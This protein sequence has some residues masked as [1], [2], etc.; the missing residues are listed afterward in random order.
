MDKPLA[1]SQRSQNF[2]DLAPD[3]C[4]MTD[5]QGLVQ[6]ANGLAKTLFNLRRNDWQDKPIS[7]FIATSDHACIATLLEHLTQ[8]AS[9]PSASS[10]PTSAKGSAARQSKRDGQRPVE[11]YRTGHT[12]LVVEKQPIAIKP[13]GKTA[14]PAAL[15]LSVERDRQGQVV[16]LYWFFQDVRSNPTDPVTLPMRTDIFNNE[17]LLI[18]AMMGAQAG[19]WD[20]D[21]ALD[22]LT[23]S[24]ETYYLH[25]L[26]P[27]IGMVS[28]DH[29]FHQ[30]LHP[31]DRQAVS[32]YLAHAWSQQAS[33]IQLEF[34]ILHPQ[35]GIR[36]LLSVGC[37]TFNAQGTPIHLNGINLDITDRKQLEQER[38]RFLAISSD[39]RVIISYD[40]PSFRWVSPTFEPTLGWTAEEMTSRPWAEFIHPD[41]LDIS[42]AEFAKLLTGHET[43]AFENRFRHQDGSYHWL[44]WK[45]QSYPEER[46]IYGA[47]ID[48]TEK[49]QIEAQFYQTQ[50]L[51]SLGTLASG[52]AH[53]LNNVLT[54]MLAMAQLL[55]LT[56]P[57]LDERTQQVLTL[58]ETSA[59]RG[60]N[61]V[62]QILTFTRGTTGEPMTLQI[63]PLL[64][65]VMGIIQQTFPQSIDLRTTFP[66]TPLWSISADPTHLH[67][68]LMNLCLNARDAMPYGGELTLTADN[69]EVDEVFARMNFN[70]QVGQ[71]V[72]VTIADTGEGIAPAMRDRIFEPFFTTK[73]QAKGTGLGLSTVLGIVKTY[74]GFV[75]V[76]S[77]VGRGSQFKVYLPTT[78]EPVS[79]LEQELSPLQGQG[80]LVLIIDDDPAIQFATQALLEQYQY[81]TMIA[82]DGIEALE[83]YA[84]RR[85]EIQV[86]LMDVMMP[87]MDGIITARTFRKIN[88]QVQ[89]IAMSG[90]S[91]KREPVLAAGAK[92][93]LAKPYT[94]EELL[95]TVS[96]IVSSL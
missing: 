54:P 20:W 79:E 19:S 86:V 66:E 25:G 65:D 60:A 95:K 48:I 93:F 8:E 53:D 80:E 72:R 91:T 15:T 73:D 88:P 34:R 71:Y 32:D 50:R 52:I 49:K 94:A 74:G 70:A 23:W 68:V 46:V 76:E 6:A 10:P 45:A 58:L 9:S 38:E 90:L 27:D 39:L 3:A 44:S 82:Q 75:Q 41:D 51:E 12:P 69:C 26:D 43:F 62:K 78:E 22:K 42:L 85:D 92:C 18:M 35:K 81:T 31:G 63:I 4:L 14:S 47:A 28:Y 89:I 55:R 77:E 61:M 96:G 24:P 64:Q 56:Q 7:Y 30:F 83:L 1:A 21:L 36:W 16:H 13:R 11:D 2:C 84:K 29:W 67:Q 5:P 40:A 37:F 87:N 57:D 17:Q 59:K 33:E